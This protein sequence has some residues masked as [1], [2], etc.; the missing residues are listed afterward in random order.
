MRRLLGMFALIACRSDPGARPTSQPVAPAY[1]VSA[2]PGASARPE[3]ANEPAHPWTPGRIA[4]GRAHTC[5]IA[6]DG[7]VWCWGHNDD[8]QLGDR[9]EVPS[10]KPVQVQGLD[11]ATSLS[12]DGTCA[13]RR[14]GSVWCW[15]DRK[16]PAPVQQIGP[17]SALASGGDWIPAQKTCALVDGAI[18]CWGAKFDPTQRVFVAV[19]PARVDGLSKIDEVCLGYEYGC[20]RDGTRFAAGTT[21]NSAISGA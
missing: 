11:A 5:V 3:I 1:S 13:V 6:A 15:G 9:R 4:A 21:T 8:G 20:A 10:R 2:T 14:D 19:P 18:W 7:T 12:A 16:P 17:A